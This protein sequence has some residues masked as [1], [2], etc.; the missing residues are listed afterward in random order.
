MDRKRID[1]S[2]SEEKYCPLP[3]ICTQTALKIPGSDEF[4]GL[5]VL[6]AEI[7][8]ICA[9]DGGLSLSKPARSVKLRLYTN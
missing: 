1:P 4:H 5:A 3:P 7:P 6:V 2:T 8:L 9:G